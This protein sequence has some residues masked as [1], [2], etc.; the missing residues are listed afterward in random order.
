VIEEICTPD[1]AGALRGLGKTAFGYRNAFFLNARPDT[2]TPM[3]VR[4]TYLN[5]STSVLPQTDGAGNTVWEYD[6]SS[7]AV[8]FSTGYVPEPGQELAVE[9]TV[10]CH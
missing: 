1:W 4:L 7:N 10:A 6:G 9:Y 3:E 8:R 2:V 5:G